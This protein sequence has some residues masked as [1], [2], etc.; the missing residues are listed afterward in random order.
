MEEKEEIL[1]EILQTK[2]DAGIANH[3]TALQ[4]IALHQIH[5]NSRLCNSF[6]STALGFLSH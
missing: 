5:A 1:K 4:S 3:C 2:C 6:M